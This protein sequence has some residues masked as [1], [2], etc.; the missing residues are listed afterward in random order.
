MA[1]HFDTFVVFAAMRTG[2][3]FLEENINDYPGLNCWG[4]SYNPHFIGHAGKD[5]LLG[6]T[7]AQRE[8]DPMALLE[9]MKGATDG[10][11]G[12]RFF[13]S[14]DPRVFEAALK[15]RRCAK[16]ILTRNPIESYVSHKIATA[17]GQWRLGDLK[18]AKSAKITFVLSEFEKMLRNLQ[19]FQLRILNGMQTSGQAG[20]YIS[21]E[22]IQSLDV[23]N[24]LA[25]F[26]GVDAPK[27][28]TNTRTKVQ[29]PAGLRDKVV[30]YDEMITALGDVD[31][32]NL[33]RIPNFEPRRGPN[34]PR[35]VAA[36]KSPLLYMPIKGGPEVQVHAWLEA[37]DNEA[38]ITGFSQKTLRQWKR[39]NARHRSFTVVRHPVARLHSVFCEY[40]LSDSPQAFTEIAQT[41]RTTYKLPLPNGAPGKGYDHDAHR[42]AFIGFAEFIKGNLGGQTSIRVDPAWATQSETLQGVSQFGL[43]D[44]VIREEDLAG[45]LA[46]MA[47]SVGL[48]KLP[49][50][51]EAAADQP[52]ALKDI[53]NEAVEAAVKAA[54]QRDYMMFG[55]KPW[56]K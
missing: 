15:D 45:D 21:Y 34:V 40:I 35:Y 52:F 30:N 8:K 50:L 55:Y 48:K 10:L 19:A 12:F 27:D 6:I 5:E 26:L 46:H 9:A 38:T 4:E 41:L 23:L 24:G 49:S 28:A 14:H 11:A 47:G 39:K 18:N 54:Y 16:I 17:T 33:G 43:P 29:N 42:A 36:G 13:P 32:F 56:G 1:Q 20:F 3:N 25:R 2:S 31:H 7:I 44:L 53:Y 37:L 51:P 22:D